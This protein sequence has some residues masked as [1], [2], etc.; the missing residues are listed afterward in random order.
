M[1]S[2]VTTARNGG[3][4]RADEKVRRNGVTRGPWRTEL[5]QGVLKGTGVQLSIG[6]AGRS[7]KHGLKY[8]LQVDHPPP[9]S[10]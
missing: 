10:R 3:L 2:V 6:T 1:F 5:N 7:V 4:S 9:I 8:Y